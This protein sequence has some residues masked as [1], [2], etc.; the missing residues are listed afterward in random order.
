MADRKATPERRLRAAAKGS[1]RNLEKLL[2]SEDVMICSV[3]G[4]KIENI[5]SRLTAALP[6]ED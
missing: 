6:E 1:I 5:I 4:A 3:A 2:A